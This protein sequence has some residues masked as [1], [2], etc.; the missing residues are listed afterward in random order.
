[1]YFELDNM[2]MDFSI[3]TLRCYYIFILKKFSFIERSN[4]SNWDDLNHSIFK[5][6]WIPRHTYNQIIIIIIII[7]IITCGH[8]VSSDQAA[9]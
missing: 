3:V 7:I 8:K 1:M 2:F 4:D 6:N 9:F 5:I